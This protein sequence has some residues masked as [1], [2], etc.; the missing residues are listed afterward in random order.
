M[1]SIVIPLYNKADTIERSINSV[2]AQSVSDWEL[3]VVDD[4]STDTGPTIVSHF[5]D[6]RIRLV[7]QVN[8]GVSAARNHG[9]ELAK[10]DVVAFVDGDDYWAP[11]HLESM[12]N[13]IKLFP[14]ASIFATAYFMVGEKGQ[15]RK[16]RLSGKSDAPQ[17]TRMMNYFEEASE[18]DPP[19]H[20]SAVAVNKADFMLIGGFPLGVKAGEDLITWARLVCIGEV[21][22]SREAT[23]YFV[24][25]PVSVA[26]NSS[27]I[28]RP[29]KP[30]YIGA[31]LAKLTTQHLQFGESLRKYLG[32]W[33]RIRAILFMELNEHVDC[34]I[35]LAKAVR[36]SGPRL[37]DFANLSLLMLP[38]RTR[39]MLLSRW[40]QRND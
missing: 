36:T 19:I 10:A 23:A 8:A 29:P 16:I 35:E 2:L 26:R 24:L 40:R 9:V 20:S 32:D 3:I 27:V 15:V 21:A 13:L 38:A 39:A 28:R 22:Y 14:E 5:E 25:P 1:I 34:L 11:G 17:T 30:D 12:A 18:G 7:T 31:E 4:G 6:P 33:H 37:R